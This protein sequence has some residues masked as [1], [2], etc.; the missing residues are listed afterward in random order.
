[1][2]SAPQ[3]SRP[4]VGVE[5]IKGS[6]RPIAG[7]RHRPRP[8]PPRGVRLRIV[9]AIAVALR[10]GCC[11][12]RDGQRIERQRHERAA[13]PGHEPA[14]LALD[15]PAD[16]IWHFPAIDPVVGQAKAIDPPPEDIDPIKS[17]L[18]SGPQSPFPEHVATVARDDPDSVHEWLSR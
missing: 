5:P 15:Q 4:T 6:A 18:A 7:Q 11:D 13:E 3:V 16:R 14:F 2:E 9:E 8:D 12:R 10:L 1:M 17:A